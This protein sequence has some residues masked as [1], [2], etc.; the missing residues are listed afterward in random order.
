MHSMGAKGGGGDEAVVAVGA[1]AACL[2]LAVQP[3]RRQ[4]NLIVRPLHAACMRG[5]CPTPLAARQPLR[6]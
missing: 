3:H 4:L 5:T 2:H 1:S 6:A